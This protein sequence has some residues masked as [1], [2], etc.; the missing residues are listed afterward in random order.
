MSQPNEEGGPTPSEIFELLGNET[1]LS[2]LQE[3]AK[4]RR[5]Y[6][7]L[8]G[9]TFAALRNAVGSPDA[10]NFS[11]HLDK[12]RESFVVQEGEEYL[13]TNAG[14]AI[15]DVV[16]T[17]LSNDHNAT[18]TT[19]TEYRCP[20]CEGSITA[21]Y[22][23]ELLSLV[24]DEHGSLFGTTVAGGVVADRSMDEV[25]RIATRDAQHSIETAC[26]GVCFHCG[27]EMQSTLVLG[28]PVRH[29]ATDERL[30][31]PLVEGT[32]STVILDSHEIIAMFGCERCEAVFWIPPDRCV[33]HHP[34]VMAFYYNHGIDVRGIPYI[35][36]R[37]VKSVDGY[38]VESTNPVGIY[39]TMT[40]TEET[41]RVTLDENMTID[42]IERK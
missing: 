10:G 5:E 3:L 2:I 4:H 20:Q 16:L 36:T 12:L 23:N 26:D 8:K 1:R 41:L 13:L 7:Q 35:D 27:G 18:R 31:A 40:L 42:Q 37:Y 9:L 28:E 29:P 17:G 33:L 39:I 19:A 6:W 34:T 22:E 11:Y 21:T 15:A 14:L 24:C 32:D 30:D 38:T 25:I